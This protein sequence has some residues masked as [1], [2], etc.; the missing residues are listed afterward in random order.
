M[1]FTYNCIRIIKFVVSWYHLNPSF[2]FGWISWQTKYFFST[3]FVVVTIA[4]IIR[5]TCLAF[6]FPTQN[7]YKISKISMA[8]NLEASIRYVRTLSE[9]DVRVTP[10]IYIKKYLFLYIKRTGEWGWGGGGGR[11]GFINFQF[12]E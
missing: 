9:A 4:I 8:M 3:C 5:N 12:I 11:A 10:Y 6:C 2:S 7:N 1:S